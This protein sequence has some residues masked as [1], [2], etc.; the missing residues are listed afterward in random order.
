MS[1]SERVYRLVLLAYPKEFRRDFGG[2][3]VQAFGDLCREEKRRGGVTGLVRV[4]VRTLA[5]LAATAFA[6]RSRAVRDRWLF[7]LVP[8]A[9]VLGL[10]IAY[11]DSSPG[12]DDTGVSAAAVLGASGLFGLLYPARPWLW[13]LAVGVWIPAYGIVRE[14]NYASL[15]ALV[16]SFA[17]AY[18]GAVVRNRLV[19]VR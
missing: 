4:W 13:A 16:F 14:F 7:M 15:L 2:E 12:W 8:L 18:A 5:D 19:P 9:L 10:T 6:E 1:R 11:V 17:G 3:M